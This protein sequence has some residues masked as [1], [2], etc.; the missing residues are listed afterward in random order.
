MDET[1]EFNYK[2]FGGWDQ[3]GGSQ[4]ISHNEETHQ[5]EISFDIS[6]DIDAV[7]NLD[8]LVVSRILSFKAQCSF[9]DSFSLTEKFM[10]NLDLQQ[11]GVV[12]QD[13]G[14]MEDLFWLQYFKD[15]NFEVSNSGIDDVAI[16]GEKA[17]LKV[18]KSETTSMPHGIDYFVNSCEAVGLDDHGSA[19][20]YNLIDN[21]CLSYIVNVDT[22]ENGK[23]SVLKT[24]CLIIC[25]KFILFTI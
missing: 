5:I 15:E 20:S 12:E 21:L 8:G 17:F 3:C 25:L 4:R 1:G 13:A 14:S 19:V 11:G 16:I 22:L 7:T 18:L 10:A 24:F 9:D 23:G 2:I 6:G